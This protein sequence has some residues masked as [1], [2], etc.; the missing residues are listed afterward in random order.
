MAGKEEGLQQTSDPVDKAI[1]SIAARVGDCVTAHAETVSTLNEHSDYIQQ[2]TDEIAL[3]K[4]QNQKLEKQLDEMGA[5]MQGTINRLTKAERIGIQN[6]QALK[7]FN[8]VVEG[9]EEKDGEN[10][11]NTVTT[12]FKSIDSMFSSNEIL[13]TYR[14]GQSAREKDKELCRPLTVKLTDPLVKQIIL[15]SKANLRKSPEYQKIFINE[16]LPPSI[17][18]E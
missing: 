13:S 5:A 4:K 9:V 6:S 14:I 12:I 10:C 11:I 2:N 17:K 15:E 8:L 7:G 3:L 1:T 18:K 16:D